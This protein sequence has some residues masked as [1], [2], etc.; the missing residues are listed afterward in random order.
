MTSG[1]KQT[2]V[3]VAKSHAE[4]E[5]KQYASCKTACLNRTLINCSL[6]HRRVTHDAFRSANK[7]LGICWKKSLFV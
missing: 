6:P 1:Y 3:G 7:P 4:S 2:E 5:F